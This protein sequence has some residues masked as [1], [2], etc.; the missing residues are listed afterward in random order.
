MSGTDYGTTT[1]CIFNSLGPISKIR[2][3]KY[4]KLS[5]DLCVEDKS[6]NICGYL[7]RVKHL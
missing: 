3:A 7:K 6:L 2:G 4:I 1:C 5:K